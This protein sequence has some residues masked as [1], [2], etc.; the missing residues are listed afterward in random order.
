MTARYAPAFDLRTGAVVGAEVTG[1]RG[2]E[3]VALDRLGEREAVELWSS[4]AGEA[5]G[6]VPARDGWWLSG[7]LPAGVLARGEAAQALI[8]GVRVAGSDPARLVVEVGRWPAGAMPEPGLVRLL[9]AGVGL[10]VDDDPAGL[11]AEVAHLPV[12]LVRLP[13]AGRASSAEVAA[14]GGRAAAAGLGLLADGIADHAHLQEAADGGA[15]VARGR[16][17]G[18]PGPLGKV[19]TTWRRPLL[20]LSG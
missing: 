13:D 3:P 11:A 10:V 5:A 20:R 9:E 12:V 17:W 19:V 6:G 8:D 18:M 15:T 14:A 2:G 7:P 1:R 4:A 16:C